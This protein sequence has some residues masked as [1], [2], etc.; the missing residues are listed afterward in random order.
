[1]ECGVGGAS[2]L[3]VVVGVVGLSGSGW[4]GD[5]MPDLIKKA[6]RNGL[7]TVRIGEL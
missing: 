7:K 1:M 4:M 5:V 3:G 6:V 2:R